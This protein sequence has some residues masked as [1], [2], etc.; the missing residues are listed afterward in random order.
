MINNDHYVYCI[1]K[2]HWIF[3]IVKVFFSSNF[4]N[5]LPC[6]CLWRIP[7]SFLVNSVSLVLEEL[8]MMEAL[9]D[10][11]H[12]HS[13]SSSQG[14]CWRDFQ[15]GELEHLSSFVYHSWLKVNLCLCWLISL[16]LSRPRR[17][18][19]SCSWSRAGVALLLWSPGW[20]GSHVR[21]L[22]QLLRSLIPDQLTSL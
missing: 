18:F 11:Q 22:L 19:W 6:C 10:H 9:E 20:L 7:R 5:G 17:W 3:Y 8:V 16:G 12:C 4:P 14:L 15:C 1:G 13:S 21:H 2:S